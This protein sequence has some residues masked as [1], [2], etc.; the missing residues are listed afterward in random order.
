[1]A[2]GSISGSG[3]P[4]AIIEGINVTPLVDIM[5]VLLVIFIV[6]AKILVAPAM[7]LDLPKASRSDAVQVVFAVNVP[8]AGPT[9]VNGAAVA[10]DD[11][12]ARQA[13]IALGKD[14]DLR[15]VIQADGGV[16]HRRVIAVLDALRRAGMTKVA[17]GTQR[18]AEAAP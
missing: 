1:M 15:A 4:G 16:P 5:L 9:L 14:R 2:G 17:F 11:E 10:G 8:V 6:T 3:R 12:L 13:A 18:E 7:P